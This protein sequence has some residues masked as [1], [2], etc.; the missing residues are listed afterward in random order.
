[1]RADTT[2]VNRLTPSLPLLYL[3]GR[4]VKNKNPAGG[5]RPQQ[6][7]SGGKVVEWI[8]KGGQNG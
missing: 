2:K 5:L 3:G 6:G 4:V 7:G 8:H 1:M